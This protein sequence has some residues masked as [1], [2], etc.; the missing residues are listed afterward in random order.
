MGTIGPNPGTLAGMPEPAVPSEGRAVLHLFCHVKRKTDRAAIQA[1]VAAAVEDDNQVIP[2]AVQGHKAD[3]AFMI[4]GSDWWRIRRLQSELRAARLDIVD[5]YVSLT[6]VSEYAQ[7]RPD[8]YKK[9]KLEPELPPDGL[10]NWCFYG[11]SRT[12][13]VGANWYT[14]GFEE[15]RK[16]MGEHGGTGRAYRGRVVQLITGSSGVDDYEWGVTL[17]ARHP[18]DLKEIV[19]E[20]RYDQASSIYGIFGRFFAGTIGTLDEVLDAAGV[21]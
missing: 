8:E 13:D 12:R 19:Y 9:A 16:L 2:V 10:A 6:E 15:R 18:D 20:M 3:I 1:A 5:S 21:P 17:F 4:I 7:S 11:M 14:L